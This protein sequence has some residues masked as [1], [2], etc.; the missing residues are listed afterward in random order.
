MNYYEI[1]TLPNLPNEEWKDVG[2][3]EGI[4]MVS[5]LGRVKSLTRQNKFG[6]FVRTIQSKVLRQHLH[7]MSGYTAIRLCK[8][9]TP[10]KQVNVHRL[11]ALAF[12]ANPENKKEVNHKDSN[13]S[14]NC[15]ENL[16][17]VSPK[18]NIGHAFD[19]GMF[20][21]SHNPNRAW[22]AAM[23]AE[24]AGKIKGRLLDVIEFGPIRIAEIAKEFGVTETMVYKIRG[25]HAW[26]QVEA[27]RT[28]RKEQV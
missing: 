28:P 27:I 6:D 21:A 16:E 19:K 13:R 25:N 14:N 17:W 22:S 7:A 9:D 5:N 2:G 1:T 12:L 8:D 3:Y 26:Q 11:V 15:L 4:Y 24:T 18:E 20:S 10:G 23:T